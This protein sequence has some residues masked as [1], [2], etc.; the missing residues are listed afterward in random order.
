VNLAGFSLG[1][2][3]SEFVIVPISIKIIFNI[4]IT[5]GTLSTEEC[6]PL[7]GFRLQYCVQFLFSYCML[8]A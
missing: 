3:M 7:R 1:R 4:F 8:H 2:H 6:L 5:Y